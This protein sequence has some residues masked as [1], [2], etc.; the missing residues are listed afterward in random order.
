MGVIWDPKG[1]LSSHR[2]PRGHNSSPNLRSAPASLS[3]SGAGSGRC[4]SCGR[5]CVWVCILLCVCVCVCAS[6]C[7]WETTHDC[8]DLYDPSVHPLHRVVFFNP[9]SRFLREIRARRRNSVNRCSNRSRTSSGTRPP[10]RAIFTSQIR[11][12]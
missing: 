1:S 6:V 10:L 11:D 2:L 4:H 3:S 9:A 7:V 5:A 12:Q 8:Y